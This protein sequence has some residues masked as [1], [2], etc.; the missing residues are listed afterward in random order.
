MDRYYVVAFTQDDAREDKEQIFFLKGVE[1]LHDS[2]Q[3]LAQNPSVNNETQKVEVL[4]WATPMIYATHEEYDQYAK[5][6]FLNEAAKRM[7]EDSGLSFKILKTISADELPRG[8]GIQFKEP[9]LP[10]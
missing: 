2:R 4:F 5:V 9:Y 3:R 10:K 8:V 1:A 6:Y 7:Y